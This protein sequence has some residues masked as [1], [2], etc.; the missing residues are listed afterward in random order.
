MSDFLSKA[1]CRGRR[2]V[3]YEGKRQYSRTD[4]LAKMM[5]E[6]QVARFLVAPPSFGKTSIILEY[7]QSMFSFE[8]VFWVNAQSPCFLRDLDK[9]IIS[10]EVMR[11]SSKAGGLVV[12][13]DIPHLDKQ[14][15]QRFSEEMDS[16]LENGWEVV[17]S[18][19]P[20][21]DVY[22]EHQS[23]R[24][25]LTSADLLLSE[26]ELGQLLSKADLKKKPV[27][28]YSLADRIPGLFWSREGA[29]VELLKSLT[30]EDIP[31]D[32]LLCIFVCLIIREG[33]LDDL[34]FFV[35]NTSKK[36]VDLLQSN[37]F[38]LGIDLCSESYRAYHFSVEALKEVF[39]S[40][41]AK[42]ATCSR[43][44]TKDDLM[45][46]L[47]D[48]LLSRH[49]ADRACCCMRHFCSVSQRSD[50]LERAMVE[51]FK[52]GCFFEAH[53]V[54]E[55]VRIHQN[56]QGSALQSAEAWRLFYLGS[57]EAAL[58]LASR[59]IQ[60]PY[61]TIETQVVSGLLLLREGN[62][63]AK[64]KSL[65]RLKELS[66]RVRENIMESSTWSEVLIEEC[67]PQD[68]EL[69][70][71]GSIEILDTFEKAYEFISCCHR[72]KVGMG[73][74]S[75]LLSWMLDE[76]N[77]KASTKKALAK[78]DSYRRVVV[79]CGN[80]FKCCELQ[81]VLIFSDYLLYS[82][83]KEVLPRYAPEY[84]FTV[85]SLLYSSIRSFEILM[86][87]QQSAF[88]V[89]VKEIDTR[90]KEFVLTHPYVN[91]NNG[92]LTR[93][94]VV[95]LVHVRL[96][97]GLEVSIGDTVVDPHLFRRQ[98]VKSLLALLIL[99]HGKEMSIRHL[100][101]ALWP[102]TMPET[103]KRNLYS[104][105]SMLKKALTTPSGTCPYLIRLQRSC[106]IDMRNVTSDVEELEKLCRKLLFGV[107]DGEE[108]L[109]ACTR[110]S[111]IYTDDLLPCDQD[112]EEIRLA[113]NSYRAQLVDAFVSASVQLL[114]AGQVQASLWYA[115]VALEKDRTRED[116]YTA[117]MTS[118]IATG[119]RSAAL[120]TF[121]TCKKYLLDEL[122]IDP[123]SQTVS[124]YQK[125]I[126]EE[127]SLKRLE[128]SY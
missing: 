102:E 57:N 92:S 84:D 109:D 122:G 116:A 61:A 114:G 5:K 97:G 75:L 85:S 115:R 33:D 45:V 49:K 90:Q 100:T 18:T 1:A 66:S 19:T 10:F 96:F 70:A 76:V 78:K 87:S 67:Q 101:Q 28:E 48:M 52:Q 118:Q 104:V 16:F 38:Y 22:E 29:E 105:W 41:M 126:E 23:D 36:T 68:W 51:L 83:L 128:E 12:F 73:I 111:E 59:V 120:E 55:S 34:T 79:G 46:S 88:E 113:R 110:I 43:L 107:V 50:W 123:S 127:P 35:K 44:R 117:L 30:N 106:K 26:K 103:A 11:K 69:L 25:W 13:E 31:H 14:R 15:A 124:L 82:S 53:Q 40:R 80:F 121:F 72:A 39:A 95:P 62:D 7:A 8:N 17:V 4:I 65:K 93:E 42:L 86:F 20:F 24:I 60:M 3:C 21:C 27:G 81:Q 58:R 89:S 9:E 77:K 37:Y 74:S 91:A 63:A 64:R 99:N 2:P 108:W 125:V 6:R 54:F 119:Q 98:K 94:E 32:L 71:I 56:Q 47:S 112:T